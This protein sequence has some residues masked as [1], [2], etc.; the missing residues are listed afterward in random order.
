MR[1][2]CVVASLAV[3]VSGLI[4]LRSE[5]SVILTDASLGYYNA[6]IGMV[7]NGSTG[8]PANGVDPLIPPIAP[9]P[10]LTAA[11]AILG[12][13]LNPN[14]LPLNLNWSAAPQAIPS[15]WAVFTET[16]ILFEF[17]LA[18]TSQLTGSFGIDNG[19]YVFVDGAYV[20]GARAPGVNFPGEYPNVN[21]GVL[22][23][24]THYLQIIREDSGGVTGW[25]LSVDATAVPEPMTL[26]LMVS[27]A[28]LALFR[29]RRSAR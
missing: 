9:A 17:N 15:T 10:D 16:A 7:L 4:P 21:L 25:N 22:G 18:A 11:A 13:W 24:G 26:S 3:V 23:A 6:N 12:G 20:W 27:G 29:R 2:S 19:M 1:V 8:F 5:A 14:P 28:A